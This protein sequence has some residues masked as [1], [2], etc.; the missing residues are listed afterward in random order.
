MSDRMVVRTSGSR[1]AE[2]LKC[3]ADNL[4]ANSKADEEYESLA[5]G[6]VRAVNLSLDAG[7][8]C[9]GSI[10]EEAARLRTCSARYALF[11]TVKDVCLLAGCA[12]SQHDIVYPALVRKED[13]VDYES[14]EADSDG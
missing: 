10:A 8:T 12:Q 7:Y 13:D 2:T 5:V 14:T 1:G 4:T 6:I 11:L 9:V 3:S